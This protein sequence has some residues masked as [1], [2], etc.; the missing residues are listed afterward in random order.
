MFSDIFLDTVD[1]DHGWLAGDGFATERRDHEVIRADAE[2][3]SDAGG[4]A[5]LGITA[6]SVGITG[7]THS[8]IMLGLADG[9]MKLLQF[10]CDSSRLALLIHAQVYEYEPHEL[11]EEPAAEPCP[12]LEPDEPPGSPAPT[13]PPAS[14]GERGYNGA[15]STYAQGRRASERPH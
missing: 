8:P 9:G 12:F 11:I 15:S 5:A 2:A 6:S 3:I 1:A 14:D 7:P 10:S 13:A 4:G